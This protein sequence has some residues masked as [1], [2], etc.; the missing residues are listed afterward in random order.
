MTE[1]VW[2]VNVEALAHFT[3]FNRLLMFPGFLN[4]IPLGYIFETKLISQLT[5]KFLSVP[6]FRNITLKCLT[7]IAG[8]LAFSFE[9]KCSDVA[10]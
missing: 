1:C 6:D 9:C 4:W 2:Q 10:L 7:E 5:F 8:I 3:G